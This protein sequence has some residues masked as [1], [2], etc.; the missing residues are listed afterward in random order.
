MT[1][2][3]TEKLRYW[4]GHLDAAGTFNGTLVD[5]ARAQGLDVKSLYGYRT[6]FRRREREQVEPSRFVQAAPTPL[7]VSIQLP[8]GV[9]VSL[10]AQG[11][12]LGE[13]LHSLARLP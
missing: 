12:E 4:Q 10:S 6:L 9:R 7:G 2:T 1:N 11:A 8:N 13:L 3:L 5:Y